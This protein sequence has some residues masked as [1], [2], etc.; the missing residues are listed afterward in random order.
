M[1]SK[2]RATAS[3]H[4]SSHNATKESP[5]GNENNTL[6]SIFVVAT[7]TDF[8]LPFPVVDDSTRPVEQPKQVIL[9]LDAPVERTIKN[10]GITMRK[11]TKGTR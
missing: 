7:M 6:C 3:P 4:L 9:L 8:F 2:G 1:A 11:L 10:V 5:R